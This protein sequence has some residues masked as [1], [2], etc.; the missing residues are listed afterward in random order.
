MAKKYPNQQ[1]AEDLVEW[2]NTTNASRPIS[3]RILVAWEKCE[4]IRIKQHLR[5]FGEKSPWSCRFGKH[6]KLEIYWDNAKAQK[7]GL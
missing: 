5:V 2:Y 1:E 7:I 6:R 3:K 4:A